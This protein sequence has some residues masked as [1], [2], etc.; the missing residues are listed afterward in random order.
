[1]PSYIFQYKI[2]TDKAQKL[3]ILVKKK[4]S[5]RVLNRMAATAIFILT[6]Y[7]EELNSVG[8]HQEVINIPSF[9]FQVAFE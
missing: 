8:Y 4:H 1:M 2:L 5:F 9:I 6:F 7:S 3:K